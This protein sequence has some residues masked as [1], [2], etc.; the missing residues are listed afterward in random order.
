MCKRANCI[1]KTNEGNIIEIIL[2][3]FTFY[4]CERN[5]ICFHR[6]ST[7]LVRNRDY[8]LNVE[9]D[10][11]SGY[12]LIVST[13][14]PVQS[15]R[16]SAERNYFN[17]TKRILPYIIQNRFL[18]IFY[19]LFRRHNAFIYTSTLRTLLFYFTTKSVENVRAPSAQLISRATIALSSFP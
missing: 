16:E 2:K 10:V 6:L 1:Y 12:T 14:K 11:H 4:N 7:E 8:I 9:Y 15:G 19:E 13:D 18:Y 17:R 3:P 5:E